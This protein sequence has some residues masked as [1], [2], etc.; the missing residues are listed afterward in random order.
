MPACTVA[1]VQTNA[2][3]EIAPNIE[4]V[5]PLIR[6][7]RAA[8]AD[9]ILLPENV[10]MIEPDQAIKRQKAPAEE[11]HPALAAFAEAAGQL[12]VWLLI[13]S[14]A[15]RSGTGFIANRS[16]LLDA[17]GRVVARYDKIHLFDVDLGNAES[18]RESAVIAPGDRLVVAT[19][20]WGRIGMSVCYDLRFAYLYRALAKAGADYLAIPAAFTRTT[21]AAHWHVLAR[22]RAIETG[23]YVLA[24]AQCG[25]HARGRRTFGHSLI[26]DP[27]GTVLADAGEDVG[28]ITARIDPVEVATA[29]RRIPSLEHDRSFMASPP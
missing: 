18:Y 17:S 24:P 16:L 29:R 26:V 15:V 19:T 28:F 4:A 7:A 6:D 1:C 5:L 14:L 12:G 10:A 20:P 25:V 9:F 27:W 8:G 11:D 22:A 13:G 23:C 2:G 3:R 21:G